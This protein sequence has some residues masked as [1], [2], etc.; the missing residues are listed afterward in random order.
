MN[1][2]KINIKEKIVGIELLRIYLSILV[3]NTHCFKN[4][5]K[6]KNIILSRILRNGLHVPTFFIISFYFFQ[7]NLFSRNL[8]KYKKRFQ[9]LLIPYL[10]WPVIIWIIINHYWNLIIFLKQ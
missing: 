1:S 9:R 8:D 7:N 2:K 3:V 6:I 10:F 4:P 5:Q